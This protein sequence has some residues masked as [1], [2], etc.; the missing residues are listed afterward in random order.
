MKQI[1][2]KIKQISILLLVLSFLS[3]EKEDEKNLPQITAGFTYTINVD[4]GTVTFI[5]ISESADS[6]EWSFGDETENSPA[7]TSTE[8]NP[9]HTFASGTYTVLLKAKNVAGASNTFESIITFEIPEVFAF[10]VTFD[11]A[12]VSYTVATFSGTTFKIVDNP[13][14][15]GTNNVASKVGEIVNSGAAFEGIALELGTDLDLTTNKSIKVNV[16]SDKAVDVLL[17][18]E[19]SESDAVETAVN[20]TGSGWEELTFSF[21][22][23]KSY[24]KVVVFIDGPGATTGTFYIDDLVQVASEE[25]PA[26]L[27]EAETMQSLNAVD[28]NLT[29]MADPASSLTIIQDNTTYEYI[30]NIAATDANNS[31]KIGK[32]TNSN[33]NP[34]DNLQIDLASKLTFT[35]GSNFTMKVYSP[36][37]GYKVTMKLED[38]NDN[39]IKTEVASSATTKTNEWEVITVPFGATDSGKYD[40]IVLFF[41]LETQN[42]NTYYF[43]DL[44]L[45]AGSGGGNTGGG[46]CTTDAAQSLSASSFDLTFLTDIGTIA[47]K[48]ADVGKFF[49][50]NTTYEYVDNPGTSSVNNSCKVG[51]ATNSNQNPWDNLQIDL[52]NKLAF[53][54]GSNFTMK[55]YSPQ[56]GYKVTLKLEDKTNGGIAKEFP[57]NET[58]TKINEWEVLTFP[59]SAA[60]ANIYDKIVLFFDLQTQNAN[61]YYFDDLKLN[62]GSGGGNTGGNSGGSGTSSTLGGGTGCDDTITCPAAPVGE[63]LFNGDFEACDCD[64]QLINNGGLVTISTTIS[65]GGTKSAQIQSAA[66]VNPALKQERLGAGLIQPNTTYVVTFDIKASGEFG[67]GGLFKAFTFSEG[68]N[69][70]DVAATQHVLTENTTSI[71]SASWESKSYTFTT[72][73]SAAQVA[74][75]IS[76]LAELVNSAASV[77]IDNVVIKAQ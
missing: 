54:D 40:K 44:K 42:G 10:P 64:W 20:H 53:T 58:T 11:N 51:K 37:S 41:D 71:S 28:F 7:T 63:L 9:I 23:S 4:T 13:A 77:N 14:L 48:G 56:S 68:E 5:N 3:C 6:Y 27:C 34:W 21:S 49:Q 26:P 67:E 52:T 19:I 22:S 50:D 30:D 45:N 43:D 36:Q 47:T 57:S 29:F 74:G 76:F 8:V 66:G 70:G 60:D 38:K 1:I 72:P 15:G 32:L 55:V 65:N 17:K 75:G 16:W 35:N 69:G 24:P 46:A 2:Q 73:G 61:T 18:L 12:K 59:V 31:C 25:S 39:S 62:L 33:Q